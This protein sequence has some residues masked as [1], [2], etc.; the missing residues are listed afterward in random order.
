MLN[1]D[2]TSEYGL[3]HSGIKLGRRAIHHGG[4]CDVVVAEEAMELY[5]QHRHPRTTNDFSTDFT[6]NAPPMVQSD[7]PYKRAPISV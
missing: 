2:E 7:C 5:K 4:N 1:A 6:T 3:G